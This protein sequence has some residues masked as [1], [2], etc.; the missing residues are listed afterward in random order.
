MTLR[1]VIELAPFPSVF[2]RMNSAGMDKGDVIALAKIVLDQF[3]VPVFFDRNL[4][5]ALELLHGIRVYLVC[6][7]AQIFV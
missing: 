2:E 6:N 7:R 1:V 4:M 5:G 3:P